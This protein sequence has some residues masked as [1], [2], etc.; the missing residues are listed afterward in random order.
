MAFLQH[1]GPEAH[2]KA[3]RKQEERLAVKKGF[4]EPTTTTASAAPA[5]PIVPT[6]PTEPTA[7]TTFI[8]QVPSSKKE[9]PE[10]QLANPL[11]F[12]N[13]PELLAEGG[14][15]ALPGQRLAEKGELPTSPILE[16]NP[17]LQDE[18]SYY[19]PTGE[20]DYGTVIKM[21]PDLE[22]LGP[23]LAPTEDEI[24]E[25]AIK[26]IDPIKQPKITENTIRQIAAQYDEELYEKTL[27]DTKFMKVNPYTMNPQGQAAYVWRN[28]EKSFFNEVFQGAIN[29]EDRARMDKDQ[30]TWWKQ[31]SNAKRAEIYT[32]A[33]AERTQKIQE[34]DQAMS[35]F[36]SRK[37]THI[38]GAERIQKMQEEAEKKASKPPETQTA[39]DHTG[40]L[41]IYN[42]DV[43]KKTWIHSG[44]YKSITDADLPAEIQRL[45]KLWDTLD[46]TRKTRQSALA[47]VAQ[48]PSLADNPTIAAMLGGQKLDAETQKQVNDIK[49]ALGIAAA[50]DILK[51]QE[52]Q[53]R[54]QEAMGLVPKKSATPVTPVVPTTPSEKQPEVTPEAKEKRVIVD[55]YVLPDN[56]EVKLPIH[57]WV[58]N[59]DYGIGAIIT[60]GE[61]Y[62]V[63]EKKDKS[64]GFDTK[65]EAINFSETLTKPTVK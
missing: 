52:Q 18:P 29:W 61:K 21:F 48:F 47:A 14:W 4:I 32:Q 58:A 22:E 37:A 64:K 27:L 59:T 23:H 55:T 57:N 60:E 38:A 65:Q 15:I 51:I 49:R 46:P 40:G 10:E 3:K 34:Y 41:A 39:V 25:S 50:K 20:Y 8:E 33:S 62:Y 43:N 45:T 35:Q 42:W 11:Q 9:T 16:F 44:K 5:A 30:A 53:K 17:N 54:A 2:A 28:T 24:K 1:S 63:V 12:T 7:P 13:R 26:E 56:P 19:L 36:K 6:V 31:A